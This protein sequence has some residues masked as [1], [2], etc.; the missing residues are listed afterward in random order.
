MAL[1]VSQRLRR[2]T[3]KKP[4]MITRRLFI[5]AGAAFTASLAMPGLV[6]A[7][8]SGPSEDQVFRDPGNPVLGN[9]DGDVTIVEFFDFQCPYCKNEFPDIREAVEKDGNVRLVMRDWPVFGA[10]SVYASHLALAAHKGGDY[11]KALGAL[12]AT[13][14]RLTDKQIDA[15]LS[16]AGLDVAQLQGA[17]KVNAKEI[18]ATIKRNDDLALSFG[19]QGTP[20]FVIGH[21]LYG[22]VLDKTALADA[23][24]KARK[25]G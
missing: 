15:A 22:G 14:G 20:S 19:F 7:Q 12:M 21:T 9:P 11:D 1:S 13:P 5:L 23:I 10:P 4:E 17:F 24:A 18:D 8:D 25:P 16:G 2:T 3:R 6:Q